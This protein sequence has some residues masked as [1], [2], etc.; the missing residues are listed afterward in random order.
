MLSLL[1]ADGAKQTADVLFAM[2]ANQ[3]GTHRPDVELAPW[4]A[5]QRWLA[6]GDCEVVIPFAPAI[7]NGIN[8]VAVRLR[9]DFGALLN[10]IKAHALMHRQTRQRDGDGRVIAEVTDYSA[11]YAL[12]DPLLAE[13]VGITVSQTMRETVQA[14]AGIVAAGGPASVSAVAKMLALDTSSAS[15]RIQSAIKQGFLENE[16][17]QPRKKARLV[18]DLPLPTTR[19]I[20]PPPDSLQVCSENGEET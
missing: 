12:I 17:S 3:A 18:L 19:G 15:R 9:R 4:H 6:R 5:Y 14:V 8:P 13:G 10:L 16:E 1:A 20:L 7:A 2:A 11:V